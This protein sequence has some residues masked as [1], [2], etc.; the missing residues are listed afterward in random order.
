MPVFD[1][2]RLRTG[3]SRFFTAAG[4]TATEAACVA[5]RLVEANLMGHDSHGVIRIPQYL[6]A[7]DKGEIVP[8]AQFEIVAETA[9]SAVIDGHWGFGQM[10]AVQAAR[11]AA[12]KARSSGLA[13]VTVRQAN[14]IGRLGSYVEDIARE[15]M[16]GLMFCN[17][18]GSGVIVAPWGGKRPRL[19]TS[20]L[21]AAVPLSPRIDTAPDGGTA[22]DLHALVLDMTTSVVAEG[23]VRVKRN[24]GEST[25]PGWIIDNEGR[26]TTNP[27]DLYGPPR[28]GILPVGGRS[29]HKGHG[30]NIVVDLLSGALSGAG[31]TRRPGA[32]LGNSFLLLALDIE[33]FVPAAQFIDAVNGLARFVKSSAL[34]EGFEEIVLPGEIEQR[35]ADKRR[36]AGV[37]VEAETLEQINAAGATF[38]V[39]IA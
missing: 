12:E 11:I 15:G 2:D 9:A 24:R 32:R 36:A 20:P 8:G 7:I 14:H 28:G 13:A 25:P 10:I 34:M 16:I 22:P 35:E 26:A 3:C 18:H 38:G 39:S 27:N 4:A 19:G 21:A 31:T 1:A 5:D 23:K 30:L 37:F 29:G 17:N 6:T 33:Q